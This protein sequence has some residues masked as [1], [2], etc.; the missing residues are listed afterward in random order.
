MLR[1]DPKLLERIKRCLALGGSSEPSEAAAALARAQ[2]MMEEHDVKLAEVRLGEIVEE[3]IRSIASATKTKAWEL[4]LVGAISRSFGCELMFR[5]NPLGFGWYVFV[6]PTTEVELAKYTTNVLQRALRKARAKFV[7]EREGFDRAD[8]TREA[9]AYCAS[10]AASVTRR[11][12]ALARAP[13]EAALLR[14]HVDRRASGEPDGGS[15]YARVRE[16]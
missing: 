10:W 8:K 16:A 5:Q 2:A 12:R 7:A 6:G 4:S 3:T 13:A 9:D 1:R 14:E 15:Q 11:V